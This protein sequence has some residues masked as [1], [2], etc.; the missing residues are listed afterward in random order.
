VLVLYRGTGAGSFDTSERR[1]PSVET[2]RY[3]ANAL[4]LLCNRAHSFAADTLESVPFEIIDS[5]NFFGGSFHILYAVVPLET[6][7]RLR[8]GYDSSETRQEFRYIAET[9]SEI[10]PYIRFIAIEL[11]LQPNP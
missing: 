9:I 2:Q 6:Y 7:E 8:N 4:G 11:D 5:T 1:L 3:V 10:G